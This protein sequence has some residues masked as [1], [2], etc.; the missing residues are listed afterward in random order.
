[1][2]LADEAAAMRGVRF[3]NVVVHEPAA[4]PFGDEQ[5]YCRHVHGVATGA[6]SPVPPCFEDRTGAVSARA[7][8]F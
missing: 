2:L 3:D 5:Y 7:E 8:R 6:T 1:V 4:R